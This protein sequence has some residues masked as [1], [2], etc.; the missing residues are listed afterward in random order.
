MP[1]PHEEEA[2]KEGLLTPQTP[3]GMTRCE[4]FRKL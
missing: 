2:R 4:F 1:C 3:I